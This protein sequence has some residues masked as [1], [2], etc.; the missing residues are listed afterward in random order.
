MA[1]GKSGPANLD[2]PKIEIRA[3]Q[4][5][6]ELKA[7]YRMTHD[8]Y[9]DMGFIRPRDDGMLIHYPHL[10]R[11]NETTVLLAL[12]DGR[13]VGTNSLTLDGPIGLHVDEDFG[14]ETN[15]IRADGRT[16]AA[17][18]R[19]NTLPEVRLHNAIVMSLIRETVWRALESDVQTCLF[20]FHK[21]HERVYQRLLNM[22]T[23]AERSEIACVEN[24][25]AVFMRCDLETLPAAFRTVPQHV[26]V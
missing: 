25:P 26:S 5:P 15:H 4:G 7:V 1:Y 20:I 23:V 19:M 12:L 16:L 24:F 21:R 10:D 13:I 3:V 8:A 18:Y 6:E 9:V 11:I 2:G 14:L 22:K 17:C